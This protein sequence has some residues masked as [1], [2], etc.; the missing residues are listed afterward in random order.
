MSRLRV[1]IIGASGI[2]KHHGKWYAMEGCDVVAFVGSS[3]ESVART[4]EAMAQTFGFDGVGYTSVPQM[5]AQQHLDAV[6]VCSPHH[7]HREHTIACL[8]AGVHVLCEKPI[9]WDL[10]KSAPQLLADAEEMIAAARDARRVL[11]VNT[12]YV[13]A[14]E[15]YLELYARHRGHLERIECLHFRM[16]SRGG[17]SGP[18]LYDEIW[19]DL[20]S[21]P[22]SLVLR[23]LPQA[24]LVKRGARCV[25]RRDEVVAEFEMESPG[26]E[27]C[28]V[29]IE[30]RNVYDQPMVRQLSVNGFVA[31]LSGANDERGVYRSYLSAG[32][33]RI[34]RQDLV[35]T[36]V[37]RFV[38]ALRGEGEP[39]ASA[40][41]AYRNL[42][43]Q[44]ALFSIARR[45]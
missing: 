45:E 1:G 35:H 14:L 22:L 2:G 16:E 26:G 27:R 37:G 32:G 44:L 17:A 7:L 12:Q 39:L 25:I 18:N 13:A 30:L 38:A 11:A 20:A 9:V 34:E 43:M 15:P 40:D 6:S 10:Q 23:L 33:E 29:S 5:L 36:S 21:H 28:A 4:R 42:E 41:E 3:P 24:R 8:G 31:D 19:I